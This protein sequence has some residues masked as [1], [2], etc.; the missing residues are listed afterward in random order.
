MRGAHAEGANDTL[1]A[2]SFPYDWATRHNTTQVG[3]TREP[4]GTYL[5]AL[6]TALTYH[7]RQSGMVG[8]WIGLWG[9]VAQFDTVAYSP[10]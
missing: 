10:K 8:L 9:G 7:Q 2:F 6:T 1:P 4:K 3:G 5:Q